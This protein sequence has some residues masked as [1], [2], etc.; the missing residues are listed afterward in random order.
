MGKRVA[1]QNPTE[2][3]DYLLD[4]TKDYHNML[5][6]SVN[7]D[8]ETY[9]YDANVVSMSKRGEDYFYML[10]ELGSG[11]YLTG[12][13]GASVSTY[14]YDE[15]GRNID[16]FTGKKQKPSYTKQGNIIQPLAFTGYQNDEMTD[17][18][19]AQARYYNSE[20]GRFVSEDKIRGFI[21]SPETINHYLYCWD[22]PTKLI[23]L[24][25]NCPMLIGAGI[26]AVF[27]GLIGGGATIASSLIKGE[28]INW[29]QVGKNA[30]KRN[31]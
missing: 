15:F 4:L 26:G 27:G 25:G 3:I 11:M 29:K 17:N 16:P 19:F 20:A 2:S 10:D 12:T 18:Y 21:D 23:D 22:N 9:T 30:A 7:G 5:E 1:V 13:D 6:R 8:V 31:N 14:A 24:D 28:D